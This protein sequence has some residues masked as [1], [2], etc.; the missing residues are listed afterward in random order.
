[1]SILYDYIVWGYNSIL[2]TLAERRRKIFVVMCAVVVPTPSNGEIG[3]SSS[4]SKNKI[5][6]LVNECLKMNKMK[7]RY[8]RLRKKCCLIIKNECI[9]SS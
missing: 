9:L 8:L 3:D 7:I 5:K 1:M 6:A 2:C 4:I